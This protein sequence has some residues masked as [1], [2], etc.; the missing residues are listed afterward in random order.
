MPPD[1]VLVEYFSLK[2]QFV[3]AVLTQEGLKIVPLTPVS[4]VI[5]LLRML[6]FQLSKFKLG[7]DYART[8]EKSMLGV[9]QAHLRQLYE[10]VFAPV[11]AHLSARHVIVVPHGVLHYL[12]FHA[13]MDDD[14]IPD[15]HLH[16]FLR[17]QCQYF[18]AL[19]GKVRAD[20]W[21][22]R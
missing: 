15:R 1:S 2:D 20:E 19:P 7:A 10:E 11:R 3:A 14:R 4:R 13:L 21:P 12:P 16:N 5:N 17:P 22:A 9:V 6:H 8:F 18:C